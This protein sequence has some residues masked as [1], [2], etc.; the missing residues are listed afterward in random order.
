MART[1]AR[2]HL[3]PSYVTYDLLN[4][5]PAGFVPP[6]HQANLRPHFGGVFLLMSKHC[7]RYSSFRK[8]GKTW[9]RSL[10]VVADNSSPDITF[11]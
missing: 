9:G 2:P 8:R 6:G 4:Q 1:L 11:S 5:I 7:L 10:I 3:Y